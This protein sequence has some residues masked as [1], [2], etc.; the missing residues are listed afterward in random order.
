MVGFSG[1]VT[2][3]LAA[4]TFSSTILGFSDGGGSAG[5]TPETGGAET[6]A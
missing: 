4:P 1:G 6:A 3:V 5:T 2:G